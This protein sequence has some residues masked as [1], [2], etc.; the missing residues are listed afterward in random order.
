MLKQM[1]WW[2]L[3]LFLTGFFCLIHQMQYL[4]IEGLASFN[5]AT[6]ELLFGANNPVLHEQRV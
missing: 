2:E 6:A 5:K 3:V 4:P 1:N